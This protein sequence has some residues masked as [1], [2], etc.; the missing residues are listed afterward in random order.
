VGDDVREPSRRGR[1]EGGGGGGEGG[2]E[3]GRARKGRRAGLACMHTA[4]WNHSVKLEG[5]RVAVIGTGASGVQVGREEGREGGRG[6]GGEGGRTWKN[7]A[8]FMSACACLSFG[9]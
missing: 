9:R 2:R 8:F 4:R 6:G 7:L 5:K 1:A 3:G